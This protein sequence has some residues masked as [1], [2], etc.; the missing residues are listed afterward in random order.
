MKTI[1]FIPAFLLAL[2]SWG[3]NYQVHLE[4]VAVQQF[5]G[6]QSFAFGH[7]AGKILIVGGRLDG[8]HRRQPWASFDAA[9]HNDQLFV[10][11][12]ATQTVWSSS[13]TSLPAN[14]QAQLSSTNMEF[15]QDGDMLYLIGGYGMNSSGSHI[16][17]PNLT[18]IDVP[19]ITQAI[20]NNQNIAPFV[21]QITHS[22]MKVT[23]GQLWKVDS[24]YYLVGGQLFDGRYNPMGPTHGPGFTQVYTDAVRRFQIQDDGVQLSVQFL[25]EYQDANLLHK[26]DYNAVP[27]IHSDGTD[28]IYAL[29]GVFQHTVDLP[30]T[31]AVHI[32]ATGFNEVTGFTHYYNQYHAAKL[33]MYHPAT[34][35]MEYI[36]F[37]GISQYYLQNGQQ[38]QDN[39]VP[40]VKTITR[41]TVDS[42]GLMT[43]T[44]L[45]SEMPDY[46]G[47]GAEFIPVYP[48]TLRNDIMDGSTMM[49]DTIEVGY[50]VGGIHSSAPNIFFTNDGT[51]SDAYPGLYRVYLIKN[52]ISIIER[53]FKDP[54]IY[55]APNPSR[56]EGLLY[57][58]QEIEEGSTIQ[59]LSADGRKLRD[60]DCGSCLSPISIHMNDLPNGTY[61][62]KLTTSKGEWTTKVTL[63]SGE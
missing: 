57:F 60:F 5:A 6:V 14:V 62:L 17:F 44:P 2:L 32:D 25:S 24:T 63:Q 28:G 59:L 49:N 50:I 46:L 8:L 4:P 3:Q 51:Q 7:D 18:A 41:I 34:R 20:I 54:E 11:D 35:S 55:F 27:V 33:F 58:N 43:E 30:W 26:R 31:N 36:L 38:V 22:D 56:G 23:G 40:F 61:I 45:A 10:I 15:Y 13:L 52:S 47:A 16:T 1:L 42:T 12:P 9:G 39:N 19:G 21:R 48:H 37:G 29:S 53:Q